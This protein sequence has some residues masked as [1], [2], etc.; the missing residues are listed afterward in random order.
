MEPQEN[1]RA[2]QSGTAAARS[3]LRNAALNVAEA[4]V[5]RS[6]AIGAAHNAG[7]RVPTA[8]NRRE[9]FATP[10]E[11]AALRLEE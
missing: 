8:R 6:K 1:H 10:P 2:L 7:V 9:R 4:A 5:E 3:R 11:A